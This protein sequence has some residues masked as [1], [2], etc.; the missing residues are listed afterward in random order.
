[1]VAVA[2]GL[3]F[4]R[5]APCGWQQGIDQETRFV[6]RRAIRLEYTRGFGN[7]RRR[8]SMHAETTNNRNIPL[9][10]IHSTVLSRVRTLY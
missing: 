7:A 8:G 9:A 2:V 4:H 6:V 1:M 5:D 3:L 10:H